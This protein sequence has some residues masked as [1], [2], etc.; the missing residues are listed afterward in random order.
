MTVVR[1]ENYMRMF[2]VSAKKQK[3]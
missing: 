3:T 2:D 1:P